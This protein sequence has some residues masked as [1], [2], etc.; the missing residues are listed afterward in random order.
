MTISIIVTNWNGL[1][2]LQKNFETIVRHSTLSSEIIF[3]DDAS[4]DDSL[5]YIYQL[6]KIYPQI[7]VI[8][9]RHNLGFGENTNQAVSTAKGE[10]LVLLNN[11]IQVYPGYLD[12]ALPYFTNPKIFGVGLC[13][14]NRPNWGKFFWQ[15]GYLQYQAGQPTTTGHI[16][17][18]LSGGSS[19]IRKDYFQKLGGFDPVYAPFYS[20]DLDLGYRAWKSG[21]DIY[22]EPKCKIEHKHESTISRF[23]KRFLDYVKER[24]RLL[25]V[26]RNI[27]DPH[28]LK[29]NKF[30]LLNRVLWGPNYIKIIL[31]ARRQVKKFP[32]PIVYPTRTDQDIFNLFSGT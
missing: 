22:W 17:G 3:A 14:V 2:L 19:I 20:E 4:T 32:P 23:P 13:E 31:A 5:R 15:D 10:L 29:A 24:N 18:W 30:A 25:T 7:K 28:L 16:S 1:K 12:A 11:D 21:F 27:T 6:Q 9:R 26:W 8:A